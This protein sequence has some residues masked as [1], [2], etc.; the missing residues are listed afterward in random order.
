MKT[1]SKGIARICS[2][3]D[4]IVLLTSAVVLAAKSCLLRKAADLS[5]V[6]FEGGFISDFLNRPG[7]ILEYCGLLL[8]QAG[9]FPAA[10]IVLMIALMVWAAHSCSRIYGHNAFIW[11]PALCMLV[12]WTGMDYNLHTM[13]AVGYVFSQMLGIA[14]AC[15]IVSLSTGSRRPVIS[16]IVSL[17]VFYPLIGGYA[18]LAAL[19]CAVIH[20]TNCGKKGLKFF[21]LSLLCIAILPQIA[22]RLA[23]THTDP[24]FT[25][26]AG[27]PYFD[28]NGNWTRYISSLSLPPQLFRPFSPCLSCQVLLPG[29]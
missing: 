24:T 5:A 18:V 10:G 28:F 12:F 16:G 4:A 20:L 11:L 3:S 6:S 17:I 27:M 26:L 2:L 22:T 8:T 25:Y 1:S 9:H 14:A 15:A 23:Y 7:G 21:C 13:R 19:C 29:P